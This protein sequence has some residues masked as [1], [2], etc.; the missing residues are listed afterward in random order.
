[1]TGL[2][3]IHCHLLP[4]LD[5]GADCMETSIALLE[6]QYENGVRTV[7]VTPHYRKD[8]FEP[9]MKEVKRAY[10]LLRESAEDIGIDLYL[11]CEYHADMDM[12]DAFLTGQRPT[13]AG[14]RY[15][16]CEFSEAAAKSYIRERGSG[17]VRSGLIPIFAHI[18]RY[19]EMRDLDFVEE[20][21]EAGCYMQ[22]NA[23]AILGDDGFRTK[24]YCKKLIQYNMI[25]F[26]GSDAHDLKKRAPNL[27][28]CAE[29]LKKKVGR[30]YTDRIMRENPAKIIDSQCSAR[31]K[32]V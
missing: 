3:D 2:Y 32:R 16:L 8:M 28:R 6:K 24:S 30:L 20:M 14:S 13:M 22:V 17:L 15:V 27:G 11:G 9:S 12:L 18:E 10:E 25:R 4:G 1:M 21:C 31:R 5:D 19:Q 23:G 26:I 29:Y 7:I